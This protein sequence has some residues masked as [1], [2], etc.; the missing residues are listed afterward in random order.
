MIDTE[1]MVLP[2][3]LLVDD[4]PAL[5]KGLRLSLQQ[6]GLEVDVAYDGKTALEIIRQGAPDL[7]VLDLMLP[8]M[9]GLDVCREVRRFSTV[10]IIILTARGEDVE[11][12]LGLEMGA[13]D[14]VAKPFNTR[15]LLARIRAQLRRTEMDKSAPPGQQLRFGSL[16]IDLPARRVLVAGREVPLTATEFDILA[17]MAEQAGRVLTRENLLEMVWGYDSPADTRTV[18]VHIRRLREKLEPDPARPR[19][20]QTKWG[21]GYY[22]AN[23]S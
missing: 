14:Y 7:V 8:G 22:L 4:E 9:H 15:E 6:A 13:D 11:K 5:V 17:V 2:R 1:V 16:V 12:I 20:V 23:E 18:D 10:P 21:V 19:W 3:I